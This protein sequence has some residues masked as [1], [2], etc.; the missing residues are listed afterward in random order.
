MEINDSLNYDE[1]FSKYKSKDIVYPNAVARYFG[2]FQKEAY[3]ICKRRQD[4]KPLYMI[5]CPFCN[6]TLPMRYYSI[7]DIDIDT[8]I[9]VGCTHCDYEFL[10]DTDRDIYVYYE[11]A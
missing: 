7:V 11:K 6:H 8:D 9:E 3:E 4:L 1:F 10:P 5:S 2:I